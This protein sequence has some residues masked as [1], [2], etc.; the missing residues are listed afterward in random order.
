MSDQITT[1]I[2][3]CIPAL[4]VGSVAFYFFKIHIQNEDRKRLFLLHKENQ[5]FSLPIRLQAYERMTL[6][7]E[8]ITPQQLFLRIP[9]RNLSK[10]E[11]EMVLVNSIDEEFEHNLAQQIYL[12]PKLWNI[13]RTAKAATIQMIRKVAYND[14]VKDAEG[15]AQ[16]IFTEFVDKSTPTANALSHLKDEVRQI[17]A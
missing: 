13:I 10:K 11:Y 14:E 3:Y 5:K 4:I 12:T 16:A 17:L 9:P 6:F 15:M 1:F 7:L 8:R 2:M